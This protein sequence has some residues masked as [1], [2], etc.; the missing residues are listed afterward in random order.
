MTADERAAKCLSIPSDGYPVLPVVFDWRVVIAA[1]IREAE[2]AA[3]TVERDRLTARIAALETA[4]AASAAAWGEILGNDNSNR[5][6]GCP[7]PE[8]REAAVRLAHLHHDPAVLRG[9]PA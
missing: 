1:T 2:A 5:P 3:T 7:D 6:G 8:F 4:L 9:S